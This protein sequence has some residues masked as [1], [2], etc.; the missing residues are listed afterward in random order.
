VEAKYLFAQCLEAAVNPETGFASAEDS[1]FLS[2]AVSISLHR[3]ATPVD[4]FS[5]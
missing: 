2:P 5:L 1:F 4:V 3:A